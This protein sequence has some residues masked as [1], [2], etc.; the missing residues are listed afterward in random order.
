[1]LTSEWVRRAHRRVRRRSASR[2]SQKHKWKNRPARGFDLGSSFMLHGVSSLAPQGPLE[3][4]ASHAETQSDAASPRGLGA[5]ARA[6]RNDRRF[7]GWISIGLGTC[8]AVA[9]ASLAAGAGNMSSETRTG[10]SVGPRGGGVMAGAG[11]ASLIIRSP[12]EDGYQ[13]A[14]GSEA[15]PPNVARALPGGGAVSVSGRF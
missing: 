6:A 4:L 5:A 2:P 10:W 11:I 7:G 8:A 12:A 9:G 15:P 1:M 3:S 14:Y 13:A